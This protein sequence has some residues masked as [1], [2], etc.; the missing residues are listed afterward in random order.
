MP[1]T[2]HADPVIVDLRSMIPPERHAMVF[3]AIEA[4]GEPHCRVANGR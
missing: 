1:A 4:L 3:A 2:T